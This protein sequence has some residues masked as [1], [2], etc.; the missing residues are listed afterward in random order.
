MF[1]HRCQDTKI[2]LNTLYVVIANIA[3]NHLGE[4]VFA[5]KPFAIIAFP[6]QNAPEAFH[7][8]VTNAMRHTR[9]ALHHSSLH[10]LVVESA[11]GILKASVAVE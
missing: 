7:G 8:T 1:F 6:F 5:G 3:M 10:E 2:V 11:A 9:H 4:A